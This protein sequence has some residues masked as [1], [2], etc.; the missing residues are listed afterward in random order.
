MWEDRDPAV[1]WVDGIKVVQVTAGTVESAKTGQTVK[2]E[3]PPF[4]VGPGQGQEVN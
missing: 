1:S 3:P 4:S 2:L